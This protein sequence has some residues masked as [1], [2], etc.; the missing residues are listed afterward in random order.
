L[1]NIKE[2]L[3]AKK[4]SVT[5]QASITGKLKNVYRILKQ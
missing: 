4:I 1:A 3:N 5:P 2:T